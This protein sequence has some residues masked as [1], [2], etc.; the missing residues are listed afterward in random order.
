MPFRLLK[1]L[2]LGILVLFSLRTLGFTP[3]Q[4]LAASL[5]PCCLGFVDVMTGTAFSLAALVFILAITA[6]IFPA[7]YTFI[8]DLV[9]SGVSQETLPNAGN[10]ATNAHANSGSNASANNPPQVPVSNTSANNSH[11][12]SASNTSM[13]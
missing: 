11:Q 5:I 1:S 10:P 13:R 2:F 4:S 9:A 12:P 6:S 8:K 7:Q 3:S